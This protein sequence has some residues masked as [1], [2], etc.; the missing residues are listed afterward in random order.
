[1]CKFPLFF[2]IMQEKHQKN[3][4]FFLILCSIKIFFIPLHVGIDSLDKIKF[5]YE[6]KNFN[7]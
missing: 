6:E 2:C 1:M 3:Y 4:F 5:I 7:P